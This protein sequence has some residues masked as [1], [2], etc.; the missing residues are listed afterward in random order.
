MPAEQLPFIVQIKIASNFVLF[1]GLFAYFPFMYRYF[2]QR[3]FG[4]VYI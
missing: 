1:L 2:H 3:T 4:V